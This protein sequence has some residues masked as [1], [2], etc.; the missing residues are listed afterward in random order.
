MDHRDT[1]QRPGRADKENAVRRSIRASVIPG[2]AAGLTTALILSPQAGAQQFQDETSTRFPQPSLNEYTNQVSLADIDNDGDIDITFA[3]G[4]NF[5]SPGSPQKVRVFINDGD[6]FFTDESD[7]RTGGIVGLYRGVE[8]GDVDD[9][10]DLDMILAADFN[11]RPRLLINDGNGFFT[12]ETSLRLP[13]NTLSSSRAIFF[14]ID[15][16]GDL[17]LYLVNGGATS[18]FGCG[19]SAIYV[20][21]GD[22]FFTDASAD[23]H[24]PGT[25]CGPMDAAIGDITGDFWLDVRVGALGNNN[26]KL[27]INDGEGALVNVSASVPSDSTCYAYDLA[28]INDNGQLDMIGINA[29]GGSTDL[30]VRNNGDGTY[31]NISNQ[32]SPN[33]NVDD[34]D[35]KFFDYDN[36]GD[37]DLIVGRLGGTSE[38]I[39]N[40]DGKGN[41]TQVNGL[42]S[43]V[44]DSTLDVVVGDLTGDGRLDIVT[45]QGESGS[46]INRIYI[47]NSGPVDTIP[48]VIV[49]T[50]EIK[51]AALTGSEN[52]YVVRAAIRD[53]MT[54]DRSFFDK[55]V[56]L[57]YSVDGGEEQ[58]V[59]MKWV[60]GDIYRGV[61][62]FQDCA[63]VIHYY[64]TAIDFNDNVGTGQTINFSPTG[65]PPQPEDLNGDC[66]VNVL[67]M[68]QL[69]G[70]WGD[71]PAKG[72]CPEDLTEDGTVNVLDLLQL[73]GA[74]G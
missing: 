21:D 29:G 1:Q 34:N 50:E 72:P 13:G 27:Y 47:N 35:S 63:Q 66:A 69:L 2:F 9:D 58:Q 3:N 26:S 61:L 28:D 67:D 6:G 16:D 30:L 59:P 55:G 22:G 53:G 36:D 73:L 52:G 5:S 48:P 7:A 60:G 38:R 42:I 25:V 15:N 17:D 45:G 70:A 23:L 20:N 51:S 18:R 46:F 65:L 39:Y 8:Y 12:N 19:P 11:A 43:N 68:L 49:R 14:D 37:F 57:N 74:W 33:P 41:F 64:V 10:G 24:P 56:H 40:N 31:S 54:S 4:G 71:C 32:L 62:P 44:T